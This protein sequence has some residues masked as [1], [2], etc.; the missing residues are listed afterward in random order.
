M[1]D[2]WTLVTGAVVVSVTALAICV[3]FQRL[4]EWWKYKS[5]YREDS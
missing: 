4:E 2:F 1:S 3:S 5:S